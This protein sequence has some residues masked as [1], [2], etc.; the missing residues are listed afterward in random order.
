MLGT[1]TNFHIHRKCTH[2]ENGLQTIEGHFELGG[3]YHYTMESLQTVVIPIE[4]GLEVYAATQWIDLTQIAIASCLNIP[5][6]TINMKVR[7]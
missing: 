5:N 6:N 2:D 1:F 3:Q 7:R 4:D